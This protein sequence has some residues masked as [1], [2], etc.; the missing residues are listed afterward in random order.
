MKKIKLVILL[1]LVS[2][3]SLSGCVSNEKVIAP[4]VGIVK[5]KVNEGIEASKRSSVHIKSFRNDAERIDYKATR[6]L[7][8]L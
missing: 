3:L 4:S 7:E 1:C 2:V 5:S 6:A 8:L